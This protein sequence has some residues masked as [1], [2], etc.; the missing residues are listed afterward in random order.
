MQVPRA[1]DQL[2]IKSFI[3]L[4]RQMAP[5]VSHVAL[6]AAAGV[7]HYR[8]LELTIQHVLA[9]ILRSRY[10]ARTPPSPQ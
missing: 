10:V 9:N 6:Q 2:D 1:C 7:V 8:R 5:P 3:I 4:I